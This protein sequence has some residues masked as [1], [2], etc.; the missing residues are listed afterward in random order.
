MAR[1]LIVDDYPGVLG[2]LQIMLTAAGHEVLM[3][4]NGLL[5]L[6]LAE[7][8]HPELMLI[9][10]EMPVYDGVALC[11]DLKRNPELA[12][13]PV[14]LM[15]GRLCLKEF[16]RGRG[17]GA[18]AIIPKPL[19]RQALLTEITRAMASRLVAGLRA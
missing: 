4:D 10:I 2:M 6:Q 7:R 17:A 3:A 19:S 1:I 5:G 12:P 15:T 13:I 16:H 14:L 11:G 9:E 8:S 18:F